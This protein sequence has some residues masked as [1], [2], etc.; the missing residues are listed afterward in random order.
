MIPNEPPRNPSYGFLYFPPFRVQG[1]SIAGEETFVQ[2]PELDICFDIGRAPR[3][4]LNSPYVALSHGHMD[5]IAG[6]VYYF[7]QRNFQGM[8]TGTVLCH[9][10]LVKPIHKLMDAW[11]DIEAQRTPY[12]VLPM[13]VGTE[14][15]EFELKNNIFLRAF[16]TDHTVPSLG[17]VVIEKRSKLREEL[18]GLP[19]EKLVE[20][21]QAGQE[22][23]YTREIPLVAYTGDTAPG[24]FFE[25]PEVQNARILVTECTFLDDNHRDRARIG[26]HLHISDLVNMMPNLK[27]EHIVLT[28]LSRRTHL[29]QARQVLDRTLSRDDRDRVH[30]LMDSRANRARYADQ[31]DEAAAAE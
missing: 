12:N 7:S 2:V 22:I 6:L 16:A 17:Y 9:P 5:H 24:R 4:S 25:H 29:G 28:H 11:I 30:V 26:K 3:L 14:S 18:V 20:M 31:M 23:T 13:E 8:G 21:K 1:Y 27:A 19:Q 15:A 10:S